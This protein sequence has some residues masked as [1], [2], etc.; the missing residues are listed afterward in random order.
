MSGVT[1]G[2]FGHFGPLGLKANW[3]FFFSPNLKVRLY[4]HMPIMP[5]TLPCGDDGQSLRPKCPILIVGH[6]ES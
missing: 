1:E 3:T 5:R 2:I 6:K 4:D